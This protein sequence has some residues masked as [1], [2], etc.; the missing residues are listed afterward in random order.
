MFMLLALLTTAMVL[1]L[2]ETIS[3]SVMTVIT[4]SLT[5][6]PSNC[7]KQALAFQLHIALYIEN[8]IVV[9]FEGSHSLLNEQ[10]YMILKFDIIQ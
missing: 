1:D 6:N 4:V 2:I 10:Y 9:I 5:Y 3:F 8:F 7:G